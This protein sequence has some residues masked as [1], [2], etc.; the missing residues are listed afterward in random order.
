MTQSD[1]VTHLNDC[2]IE[3]VSS[4]KNCL[5]ETAM[6]PQIGFCVSKEFV[7]QE[8]TKPSDPN[9]CCDERSGQNLCFLKNY[10]TK[11]CLPARKL[12]L[13]K[14]STCDKSNC[15][16]VNSFCMTPTSEFNRT[17]LIQIKRLD[18][19]SVLFWGSPSELF[20]SVTLINYKPKMNWLPLKFI[21]YY[22]TLL[23]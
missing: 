7:E 18:K 8:H 3:D 21:F 12:L 9:K 22:E 5:I 2:K 23:R 17:K 14:S 10:Q 11:L 20:Q 4:W 1:L 19:K 6:N 13:N 16:N 15:Q